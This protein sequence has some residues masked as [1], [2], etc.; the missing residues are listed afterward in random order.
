MKRTHDKETILLID[1]EPFH[2]VWMHDYVESLGYKIEQCTN[3]NEGVEAIGKRQY[4]AAIIDLNISALEPINQE[5][6]RR[7]GV[8]SR[9]PGLFAASFA[10]NRGYRDRQVIIY[11]VHQDV[12]VRR[13]TEILVSD[14]ESEWLYSE[15]ATLLVRS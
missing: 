1:D 2:M 10:R 11:S 7:S 13:E 15:H 14:Y 9:Y 8:Y 3:L 5:L 12:E 6:K 4:R